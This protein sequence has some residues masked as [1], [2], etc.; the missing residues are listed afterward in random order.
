MD[1][2]QFVSMF[3]KRLSEEGAVALLDGK[4][5]A[6]VGNASSL[7]DREH[8]PE[9]DGHDWVIRHN[10]GVPSPCQHISLGTKTSM[11]SGSFIDYDLW[12]TAGEP[13]VWLFA[14]LMP[15]PGFLGGKAPFDYEKAGRMS[16][17]PLAMKERVRVFFIPKRRGLTW[18]RGVDRDS[19]FFETS[20][21][22]NTIRNVLVH[23]TP[24][25]ITLY[26]Y[27][28]FRSPTWTWTHLKQNGPVSGQ[29]PVRYKCENGRWLMFER[30]RSDVIYQPK[31][32]RYLYAG[33]NEE[34]F[35]GEMGFQKI[36]DDPHCPVFRLV[37]E[38]PQC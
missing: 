26:G 17:W 2:T 36:E 9:I 16:D 7:L 8:G 6:I 20:S 25:L 22:Q 27:D 13:V 3:P 37:R 12:Q 19:R 30:T 21:G 35:V 14:M 24:S 15:A 38:P 32:A 10:M 4:T 34:L 1:A 31:R 11:L 18:R 23:C 33:V 5:V 28:F 29:G